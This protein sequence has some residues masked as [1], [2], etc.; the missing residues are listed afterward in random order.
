V[1]VRDHVALSSAT[2][3]LL[4]PRL[5]RSVLGAWA[6]SILI[7]VDHYLW[8]AVRN[9]RLN[10][11]EAVRTFNSA[12]STEHSQTRLLHHPAVL[13]TLLLLSRRR[14]A[15]LL[16]VLGMTFHVGL[17]TYHRARTGRARKAALS[18]DRLTCQVCDSKDAS[19]VPHLWRQPRVLP[20]YRVEHFITLC[21]SCH[22]VAHAPGNR[23]IVGEDCSWEAYL[24]QTGLGARVGFAFAET[25]ARGSG[26]PFVPG[27]PIP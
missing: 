10:P 16:P 23:A 18:R 6:A 7:D 17:D 25:K 2:A 15:F 9:R 22:E 26:S 13:A 11:V 5:R 27:S 19:V 4:Y 21:G 24:A 14:R 8:F 1:R 12:A 20:S 3:A